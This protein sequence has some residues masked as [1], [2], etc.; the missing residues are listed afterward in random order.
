MVHPLGKLFGRSPVAPLQ[1]HMQLVEESVQL[2]CELVESCAGDS[3]QREAIGAALLE[4]VQSSRQ[5]RREIR[6]QMPRGLLLAMPRHDLLALLAA[7]QQVAIQARH[8]SR[9]LLSRALNMPAGVRKPLQRLCSLLADGVSQAQAAVREMDEM[10]AQGFG[11][12]AKP[13]ERALSALDRQCKRCGEQ[14]RR[15]IEV[16]GAQESSLSPV[17]AMFLYQLIG[18]LDRLVEYI[19]EVGEQLRLIMAH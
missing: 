16:L 4:S 1:K 2:L 18:D 12:E 8:T 3:S 15:C 5:L 10:L 14:Q 13:L 9:P 17:D 7:Q 19:D 11:S 6:Q